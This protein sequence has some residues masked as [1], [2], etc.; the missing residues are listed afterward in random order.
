M[1]TFQFIGW[2]HWAFGFKRLSYK[3]TCLAL[4]Y[5]W[6]LYLGPLEIRRWNNDRNKFD[7]ITDTDS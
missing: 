3:E 1:K 4:I 6:T 2:P 5:K 7:I